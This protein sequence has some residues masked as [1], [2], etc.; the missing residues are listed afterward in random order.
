V[1][2]LIAAI[3]PCVLLTACPVAR[4]QPPVYFEDEAGNPVG[5]EFA[6]GVG[7]ANVSVGGSDSPLHSEDALRFDPAISIA[8]LE[9][10][11]QLRLGAAFGV[12][13]VIDNSDRTIISSGGATVIVGSSEI[14]LYVLEPE[15]RL[16]WRQYFH[17]NKG[18]FVEPGVGV[19]GAIAHVSVHDDN[20]GESFD[21]T[22]STFSGR[23]FLNLG[24]TLEGGGYAGLQASYMRGGSM[25]FSENASGDIEEFYIGIYGAFRF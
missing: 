14:P 1:R 19:G 4:A 9:K 18:L 6:V 25:H 13:L 21:D 15:A 7:Y 11:P 20:T 24:T 3:L 5:G 17:G 12:T 22:E 16:S 10:L 8:P 2:A 23:A